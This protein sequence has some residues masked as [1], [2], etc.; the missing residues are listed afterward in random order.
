MWFKRS[1]V[2][3]ISRRRGIGRGSRRGPFCRTR[4]PLPGNA[5]GC[6]RSA[7]ESRRP[8][9]RPRPGSA[10]GMYSR[11]PSSSGGMNSLP[12]SADRPQRSAGSQTPQ[13]QASSLGVAQNR[14]DHRS[15]DRDQR[16]IE[17]IGRFVGNSTADEVNIKTGISVTLEP[18]RSGHRIGLRERQRCEELA[19]P[20]PERE[21]RNED[22]VTMTRLKKS[23]G[24]TS[25]AASAI[26]RLLER[27][28]A[29]DRGF[30]RLRQASTLLCAFSIITTAA[31]TMAP[32]A[33]AMPPSDMMLALI[34]APS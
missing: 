8:S 6:G 18:S 19:L 28:R 32:M 33:I 27:G 25:T 17:W 13:D 15:I 10:V 3:I 22:S 7:A 16:P 29:A 34:P 26:C 30:A 9:H 23:A 4:A 21:D 14:A 2:S 1:V 12:R 24:P 31:S 5:S 11:S 20:A